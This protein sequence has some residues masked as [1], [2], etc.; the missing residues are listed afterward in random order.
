MVWKIRPQ[1]HENGLLSVC[2]CVCSMCLIVW[3]ILG[4]WEK[5]KARE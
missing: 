5:G 2:V 1:I 4:T 3:G